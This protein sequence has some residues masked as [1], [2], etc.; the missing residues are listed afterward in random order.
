LNFLILKTLRL[1]G[2]ARVLL[3]WLLTPHAGEGGL[4]LLLEAGDPFA[5]GGLGM[6]IFSRK[7]AETQ[8]KKRLGL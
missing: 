3:R 1:C 5:V 2:F 4:D 7:A 6:K 8:R